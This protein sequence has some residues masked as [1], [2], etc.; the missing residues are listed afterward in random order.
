MLNEDYENG[1][2]ITSVKADGE[3][4]YA[5]ALVSGAILTVYTVAAGYEF[6]MTRYTL[7]TKA[8]VIGYGILY[9]YDTVPAI[10][11]TID[12][13]DLIANQTVQTNDILIPPL[14]LPTGYA[15]KVGSNN[16]NVRAWAT[17]IGYRY[18]I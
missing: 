5:N 16:M 3:L 9:V 12:V 13:H 4:Q 17:I 8:L 10:I 6:Y 11:A 7:S 18:P 14:L 2:H 1:L 15:I